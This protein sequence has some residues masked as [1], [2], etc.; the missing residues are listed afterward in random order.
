[1]NNRVDSAYSYNI[2]FGAKI[3]SIPK[4]ANLVK[5]EVPL[6][7]LKS[8][9]GYTAMLGGDVFTPQNKILKEDLLFKDGKIVAINDFEPEMISREGVKFVSLQDK[10]VAPAILDEHIH[11]G[12]GINFHESS[13]EDIRK[14]LK[15]LLKGGTGAVVATTLPG[16]AEDI[17]KAIQTLS[18]IIKNPKEGEARIIGIHLEGPFLSPQKAGIHPPSK[19]MTPTIENFLSLNP[20]NIKIVTVAPELDEGYKLCKYL[21]N[22]GVKVSAGHSMASAKQLRDSCASQVTHIFNAMPPVHHRNSTMTLEAL[23]NN[24]ISAEMNSDF[25]L[26]SPDIMNLIM[27]MKPKDK[28]ILISDALPE[29]GIKKDFVMNGI[30]IH[31]DKNWTAMSD[32]GILAGSLQFLHSLARKLVSKTNMTFEDFIRYASVNPSKNVGVFEKFRI[33]QGANPFFTIWNN[34]T[35]KPEKTFI[36]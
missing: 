13:E 15:R 18:R 32:S 17:Q 26:L 35:I 34:K 25:S 4:M 12:Y 31:V 8:M 33:E 2:A 1:M 28:L 9:K 27:R 16:K 24:N 11:G 5:K 19:L 20:E 30:P 10:T 36:N 14:L 6:S 29:S 3:N 7:D 23:N 21:E 22:H